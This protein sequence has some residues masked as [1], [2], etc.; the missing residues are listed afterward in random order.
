LAV[1][2]EA[3]AEQIFDLVAE[4]VGTLLR[5]HAAT[6][7]RYERAGEEAVILGRWAERNAG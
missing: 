4:K 1:A 3:K 5:A 2:S 7:F 6:I